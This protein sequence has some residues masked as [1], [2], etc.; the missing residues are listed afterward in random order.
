MERELQFPSER[1]F[2]DDMNNGLNSAVSTAAIRLSKA[3]VV[4]T[5]KKVF[6]EASFAVHT[7][8]DDVIR[9]LNMLRNDTCNKLQVMYQSQSD[10]LHRSEYLTQATIE[11]FDENVR[12]ISRKLVTFSTHGDNLSHIKL[13]IARL[14]SLVAVDGMMF[15]LVEPKTCRNPT[16][17]YLSS[18]MAPNYE[19]SSLFQQLPNYESSLPQQRPNF[20]PSLLLQQRPN[21]EPSLLQQRSS[22]EQVNCFFF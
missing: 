3:T 2:T 14:A 16:V 8:I 21:F 11:T 15:S 19:H 22:F 5:H 4:Q 13:T 7:I 10:I 9:S 6:D 1:M 17:S 18:A 12:N 20:E